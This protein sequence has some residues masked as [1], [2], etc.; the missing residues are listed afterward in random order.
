[1]KWQQIKEIDWQSASIN[2]VIEY[3]IKSDPSSVKKI[4]VSSS[5][6]NVEL[7][8]LS[9]NSTYTV[10]VFVNNTV[11]NKS[12]EESQFT[13]NS[14]KYF[15]ADN[16]GSLIPKA[17]FSQTCWVRW[18]KLMGRCSISSEFSPTIWSCHANFSVLI[19]RIRNQ[20]LKK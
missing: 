16:D 13:T 17:S 18:G 5:Q 20:F 8:E 4:D 14:C 3:E 1:M 10:S 6:S 2:Y 12:S 9:E 7:K 15:T 19:D 11:G